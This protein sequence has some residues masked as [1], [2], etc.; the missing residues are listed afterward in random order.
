[1]AFISPV[2]SLFFFFLNKPPNDLLD[3]LDFKLEV[4]DDA[5]DC[6]VTGDGDGDGNGAGDDTCD[7]AVETRESGIVVTVGGLWL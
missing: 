5:E 7:G 1:M 3:F 6:T 4:V 2:F